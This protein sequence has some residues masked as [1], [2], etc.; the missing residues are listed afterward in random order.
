[1]WMYSESKNLFS[2]CGIRTVDLLERE[3]KEVISV[4]IYEGGWDQ[5]SGIKQ[6]GF[7]PSKCI[8]HKIISP[9]RHCTTYL[10]EDEI[11]GTT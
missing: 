3:M 8:L 2:S 4:M 9:G 10:D 11:Q 5:T 1:M 7:S 6:R